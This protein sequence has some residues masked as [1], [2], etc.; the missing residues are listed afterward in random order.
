MVRRPL[1]TFEASSEPAGSGRIVRQPGQWRA[2]CAPWRT[3][4]YSRA[5]AVLNTC[6]IIDTW[7]PLTA[8]T[9]STVVLGCLLSA[10]T[11]GA[12]AASLLALLLERESHA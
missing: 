2:H 7:H 8:L 11:P 5:R 3:L 1:R 12:F 10:G 9:V 4:C 6:L